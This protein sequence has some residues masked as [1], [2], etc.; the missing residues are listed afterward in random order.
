MYN[1]PW[2]RTPNN[3]GYAFSMTVEHTT[4]NG[5]RQRLIRFGQ[6]T[7]YEYVRN[8][9]NNVWGEW[10][11]VDK[12]P[13]IE[14]NCSSTSGTGTGGYAKLLDIYI[15]STYYNSPITFDIYQRG[16]RPLECMILF[17]NQNTKNPTINKFEYIGDSQNIYLCNESEQHYVLYVQ[18]TETNDAFTLQNFKFNDRFTGEKLIFTSLEQEVT[19]ANMPYQSSSNYNS[20]ANDKK[21]SQIW[22][23]YLG[24]VTPTMNGTANVGTSTQSARSDHTHPSDT[25]KVNTADLFDLI[26]PV[27]SIYMSINSTD[28]STLFGGTW[29]QIKDT[30]LLA[31]G[32]TYSNG[33]TGGS[34]DAIVVEHTHTQ[35]QHRHEVMGS[36]SAG[37][38]SGNYLRA[39]YGSTKDSKY[40]DYD[41]P[42]INPTGV[43]GTGKNMPPYMSV[44]MWKRTS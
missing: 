33:A 35:E 30:F 26:Y 18:K 43:D 16:K 20:G 2:Q 8:M 24:G 3:K 17:N 11:A 4:S 27:G 29:T 14:G 34:A 22:Q 38:S 13:Y 5:V 31:C 10:K 7:P 40:T 9:Y 12:Q 15:N 41:T 25:S 23:R 42:T 39:G 44:Y 1:T 6:H 32:D 21:A 19:S 36:K 37:L 28:P